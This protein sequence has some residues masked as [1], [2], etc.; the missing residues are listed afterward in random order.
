MDVHSNF[1]LKDPFLAVLQQVKKEGRTFDGILLTDD[2]TEL[3]IHRF[4]LV[5]HSS[6]FRDL[7]WELPGYEETR[8]L[9]VYKI[10]R[11]SAADLEG[12]VDYCYTHHLEVESNNVV[13]LLATAARFRVPGMLDACWTFLKDGLCVDNCLTVMNLAT[14]YENKD[15]E[16]A[17][18]RYLVR[19]FH[20]VSSSGHPDFLTL[21]TGELFA[22]LVDDELGVRSELHAVDAV[23]TWIGHDPPARWQSLSVLLQALHLGLVPS[24]EVRSRI[25]RIPQPPED[26]ESQLDDVLNLDPKDTVGPFGY[27]A[28]PRIPH[29]ILFAIGGWT[30]GNPTTYIE[31]YDVRADRWCFSYHNDVMARAYHRVELLGPLLYLV[32]GFDGSR[33]YNSVRCFDPVIKVWMNRAPMYQRRCYISTAVLDGK[34]YAMGGYDG[35]SRLNTV[36]RYTPETN[37]WTKVGPMNMQRSDASATSLKDRIYIVGGFTG[38]EV[39]DSAEYYDPETD[40]WTYVTRMQVPRSGVSLVA[41]RNHLYALGGFNGVERLLGVERYDSFYNRWSPVSNMLSPR[42]NFTAVVLEEQIYAIGGYDGTATT[43]LAERYDP[44]V[45]EWSPI[46]PMAVHRSAL[47]ACTVHNLSNARDYSYL[48]DIRYK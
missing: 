25:R 13:K 22:L 42:S 17:A 48:R 9:P 28:S 38:H 2:G 15:V 3:R 47:C 31:T 24:D 12:V 34:L 32:G 16:R 7:F 35:H 14:S 37:E 8:P 33:Y 18:R 5:L 27:A 45:D 26:L 20:K 41:F 10:S 1:T 21:S 6:Y 46:A 23:A 29:D 30:A 4:L 39:L 11:V 36:E 19:N 44:S 43:N 40:A